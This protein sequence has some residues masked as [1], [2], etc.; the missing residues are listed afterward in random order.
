MEAIEILMKLDKK[1]LVM[2]CLKLL[3][4]HNQWNMKDLLKE[5]KQLGEE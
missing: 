4:T 3:A 2:L 1:V 5:L